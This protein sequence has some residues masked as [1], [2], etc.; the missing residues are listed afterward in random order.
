MKHTD[1]QKAA[2]RAA[3]ASKVMIITGGPSVGKSRPVDAIM[4]IRRVI[5][6]DLVFL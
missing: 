2:I 4:R 3:L 5:S 6:S 1:S